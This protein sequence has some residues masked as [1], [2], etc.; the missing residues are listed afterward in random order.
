MLIFFTSSNH[1]ELPV[2]LSLLPP[3]SDINYRWSSFDDHILRNPSDCLTPP[4]MQIDVDLCAQ[5]LIMR[6]RQF[7]VSAIIKTLEV[8]LFAYLRPFLG[9][10]ARITIMFYFFFVR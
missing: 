2:C 6:R 5:C 9:S 4:Q 8:R 1:S 7:H 3:I 10:C